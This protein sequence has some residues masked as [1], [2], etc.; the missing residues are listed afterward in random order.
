MKKIWSKRQKTDC[1]KHM[2]TEMRR[3]LLRQF[4]FCA[5]RI[6]PKAERKSPVSAVLTGKIQFDLNLS[7]YVRT[8]DSPQCL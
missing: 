1:R 5:G 3:R 7:D 8:E 2:G 6:R 4:F